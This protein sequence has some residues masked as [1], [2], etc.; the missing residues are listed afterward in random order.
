MTETIRNVTGYEISKDYRQL[1]ELAKTQSIVCILDYLVFE[2][3]TAC[4]DVV[5]TISDGFEVQVCE[6]GICFISEHHVEMFVERCDDKN[7]EFIVPNKS[8]D[9]K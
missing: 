5:Q 4:R 3:G 1:F 8:L 7:L 6:R 2:D 9:V